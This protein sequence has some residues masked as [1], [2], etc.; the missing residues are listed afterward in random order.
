MLNNFVPDI[1]QKSIFDIDYKKLKK[2][3]IKCI[4]FDLDNTMVPISIKGPTKRVKDLIEDI[5][6]LKLKI[7]IVSNSPKKRVEPFKDLLCVDSA[8]FAFK[9]LKKKYKKILHIYRYKDNEIACIGDQ[10]L[11][12]I[13]GA[14]RMGFISILVNPIGTADFAFTKLNRFIEN[15]IYDKLK[16]NDLLKKGHYYD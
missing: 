8:Y 2:N 14:N 1:Y 9:P 5:K 11:T 10:L 13:W 12:D 3:G 7:I 16:N 15:L 4:I 6:D